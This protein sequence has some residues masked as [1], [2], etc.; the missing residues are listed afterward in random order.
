MLDHK[1]YQQLSFMPREVFT[2]HM[3]FEEC[4]VFVILANHFENLV[5]TWIL[6]VKVSASSI[7]SQ[8]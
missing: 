5:K 2:S 7:N 8:I 6:V 1:L 3:T 4:M